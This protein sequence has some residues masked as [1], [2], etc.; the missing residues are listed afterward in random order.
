MLSPDRRPRLLAALAAAAA[1]CTAIPAFAAQIKD[2]RV[3]AHPK[4]TRIVF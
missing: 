3:G 2:V 4:F 1:L